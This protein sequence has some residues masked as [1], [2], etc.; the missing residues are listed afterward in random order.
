M[1][2]GNLADDVCDRY[3]TTMRFKAVVTNRWRK[4]TGFTLVEL[5][6]VIVI[7]AAL[8]AALFLLARRGIES[9]HRA[10]TVQQM[11]Q[12]GSAVAMWAGDHNHGEPMYFAN[13]TGDYPEEGAMAGKDPRLS[14]GNP[15]KL[16]YIKGDPSGS[17]VPSHEVFFSGLTTYPAPSLRDYD[18]NLTNSQ[19]PWGTFVWLY[20]STT[21]LT[22]RQLAAMAGFSNSRIGREASE[23]LIMAN[24]YRGIVK[25]KF[26]PHYHAL[27]RDGSVRY[28]GDSAAKWNAWLR[29]END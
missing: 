19:R 9:S 15:A 16:L 4:F 13:G 3:S 27:F 7:I 25:A 8:S 29:G 10:K 17:Y 23:N 20:P 6:V 28:I 2:P 12:I 22:P 1:D 21:R 24:E 26:K 18:P 5:L 14:P 11:R